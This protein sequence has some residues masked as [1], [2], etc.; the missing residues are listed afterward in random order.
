MVPKLFWQ[1]FPLAYWATGH[2]SPLRLKSYTLYKWW[3]VCE[4]SAAPWEVIAQ[5]GDQ[6]VWEPALTFLLCSWLFAQAFALLMQ[7]LK[8]LMLWACSAFSKT[9]CIT[10]WDTSASLFSPFNPQYTFSHPLCQ[11]LASSRLQ[12]WCNHVI[13]EL[14]GCYAQLRWRSLPLNLLHTGQPMAETST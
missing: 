6:S 3:V 5:F 2:S 8:A 4:D 10:F 14:L 9:T 11:A 7:F 1:V 12:Q 13:A